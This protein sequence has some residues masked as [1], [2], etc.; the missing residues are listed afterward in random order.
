MI[1]GIFPNM[2]KQNISSVLKAIVNFL[3]RKNIE[4]F[5]S[6]DIANSYDCKGFDL[7]NQDLIK[8]FDLAVSLGGDGTFLRMAKFVSPHDIPMCGVN[9][10]RLGFLTEVDLDKLELSLELLTA[11]RFEV[12]KR[13]MLS[14]VVMRA[15]RRVFQ[16]DA[17]NDIVISRG[18]F[19][20]MLRLMVTIGNSPAGKYPV[21]GLI[22]ATATGST[23][24]SLSAGGAIVHPSLEVC[25]IT[26]IASHAL[27]T[28][29]FIVPTSENIIT[30]LCGKHDDVILSVDGQTIGNIYAGDEIKI[31][32]SDYQAL[33]VRVNNLSYY[34]TWQKKL[35][36]G[37]ES[38]N[39]SN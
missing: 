35:L 21:D 5:L 15:G 4:I 38:V 19:S 28:R 37:E 17:L 27:H 39:F 13:A 14:V 24:Y 23:G 16:S 31:S 18:H 33:F 22:F 32:K 3:K 36:R 7:T 6:T 34:E 20:S 26:P 1:I 29:P 12:E 25:L 8:S 9:L 2:E 10:G 30:E 11:R